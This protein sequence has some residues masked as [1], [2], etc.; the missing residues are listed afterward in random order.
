M[1]WSA[2][3]QVKE[4]AWWRAKQVLAGGLVKMSSAVGIA[5]VA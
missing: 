5:L 2:A 4:P 1:E 3:N